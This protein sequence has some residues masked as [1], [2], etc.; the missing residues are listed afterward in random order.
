MFA[1][2][3]WQAETE[4]LKTVRWFQNYRVLSVALLLLTGVI[5]IWFA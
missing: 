2:D 4:H 5:V 1:K 3:V